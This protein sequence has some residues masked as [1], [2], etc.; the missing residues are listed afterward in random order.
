MFKVRPRNAV[1]LFLLLTIGVVSARAQPTT[2]PVDLP[3][4]PGPRRPI[5]IIDFY[6]MHQ[7]TAE[8]LRNE[9]TFKVGDSISIDD[10]SFFEASKQRLMIV[11]GVSRARVQVVCCTDGRPVVF[12][13]IEEKNAPA[14]Q[15]RLLNSCPGTQQRHWSRCASR[16][17]Q[18]VRRRQWS[19]S[20]A[21]IN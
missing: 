10:L 8:Q 4:D 11:P 9:L 13:G 18:S 2:G 17:D 19:L 20:F 21:H 1:T 14:M 16:L 5:G 7:L 15:F 12:V 3:T 6:G